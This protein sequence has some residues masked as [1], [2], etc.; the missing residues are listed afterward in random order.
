MIHDGKDVLQA[1]PWVTL[2]PGLALTIVVLAVNRLG[3]A[4]RDAADPR[5]R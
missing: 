2:A 4:V 3:D 5:S 1:A